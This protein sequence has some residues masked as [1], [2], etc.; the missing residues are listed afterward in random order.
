M[1]KLAKKGV[2]TTLVLQ[3]VPTALHCLVVA[4]VEVV[5]LGGSNRWSPHLA[6][7]DKSKGNPTAVFSYC[8]QYVS[9]NHTSASSN[10][11]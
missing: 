3:A 8:C 1:I 4:V 9:I 6:P 5:V 10:S 11:D 7:S 2:D